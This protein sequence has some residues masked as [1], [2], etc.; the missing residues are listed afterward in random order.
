MDKMD[1]M[2]E[3]N[4]MNNNYKND[5]KKFLNHLIVSQRHHSPPYEWSEGIFQKF[6]PVSGNF[7]IGNNFHG[8]Q[9]CVNNQTGRGYYANPCGY[10]HNANEQFNSGMTKKD[11]KMVGTLFPNNNL[12]NNVMCNPND[13]VVFGY[14]R[15]GEDY[16]SR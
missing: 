8:D 3:T 5:N 12:S 1:K 9:M 7:P 13:R 6:K 15:I 2:N 14:V 4:E 10:W 16:R 11:I